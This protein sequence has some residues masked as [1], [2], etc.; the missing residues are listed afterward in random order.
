MHEPHID[1]LIFLGT[2]TSAQVPAIGCL[3]DPHSPCLVCP[4]ALH[5][6]TRKN[7]RRNTSAIFSLSNGKNVMID[8]GKSFFEMALQIWPRAKLR[9]IDALLLTHAHAD[10]MLGLDDL[11]G[12][13]LYSF[14][15][16]SIPIYCTKTTFEAVK[17]MFPY[18]ID[19]GRAT[20][21]GD[22]PD[23]DWHI[24]DDE[25][26]FYVE[27]CGITIDPLKVEHGKYFDEA[28]SPFICLGFKLG[29]VSYVSDASAIPASTKRKIEGS[30]VLILDALKQEPH[31]SHFSIPESLDF[32][33]TSERPAKRTYLIDF[34]H[35]IDHYELE[36]RLKETEK[37]RI[38]PAYDGLQL[39]FSKDDIREVD[40]LGVVPWLAVSEQL[41]KNS[42]DEHTSRV[43]NMI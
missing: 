20:G 27:S 38:A 32:V 35:E 6:E 14:I 19:S 40:L 21:G 28:R 42:S 23:T 1:S 2:G 11:R 22:I 13:T 7:R 26:E 16:P 36:T 39:L 37:L 9:K 25:E 5:A 12:W 17:E 10:A 43:K 31:S 24:I 3:T 34:T 29:N 4:S 8:C 18:M 30:R 33:N 15:Q 41:Y